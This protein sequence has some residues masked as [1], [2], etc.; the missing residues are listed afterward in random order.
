MENFEIAH[1]QHS[2][3]KSIRP[4]KLIP[5]VCNSK[6]FNDFKELIPKN[7][8]DLWS[9]A[10]R[11]DSVQRELVNWEDETVI[12]ARKF[13]TLR[14]SIKGAYVIFSDMQK[15]TLKERLSCV[16]KTFNLNLTDEAYKDYIVAF[17]LK[18][19]TMRDEWD[20][21]TNEYKRYNSLKKM[22]DDII[23]SRS[24]T[25]I[26][27]KNL[28]I[29]QG[30]AGCCKT[31][32]VVENY[33][34][35]SAYVTAFNQNLVETIAK[36]RSRFDK[37]SKDHEYNTRTFEMIT[38]I[39]K[40][41]GIFYIDEAGAIDFLYII[42]YLAYF[43]YDE[44]ILMGDQEQ[45]DS[46]CLL[47]VKSEVTFRNAVNDA[48]KGV[49]L[50][51]FRN[52][53][54]LSLMNNIVLKYC[55]FSLA[56]HNTDIVLRSPNIL[57]KA[58]GTGICCTAAFAINY[59]SSIGQIVTAKA[60]QGTTLKTCSIYAADKME[61]NSFSNFRSNIL[62]AFTRVSHDLDLYVDL[63]ASSGLSANLIS[64][65]ISYSALASIDIQDHVDV[66]VDQHTNRPTNVD[67]QKSALNT[68]K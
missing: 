62:V 50:Y 9:K 66:L 58:N 55:Q 33:K 54:S 47:G 13:N 23:T 41:G 44:F 52:G 14:L 10:D 19:K 29:L 64:F 7:I 67:F 57:R 18:M 25:K 40:K 27:S 5:I 30:V 60:S 49:R 28:K 63:K 16:P 22:A 20:P 31:A 26:N 46:P 35:N 38:N 24:Y 8:I 68:S 43:E 17:G 59:A 15:K 45:T 6:M 56:D 2:I 32:Y 4:S 65:V 11:L 51:T 21:D 3:D 39:E 53:A 1:D 48:M 37:N 42:V 34:Y 12:A 36:L 61:L